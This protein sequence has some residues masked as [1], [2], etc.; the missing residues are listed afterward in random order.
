M[1]TKETLQNRR[2]LHASQIVDGLSELLCIIC[3]TNKPREEFVTPRGFRQK[4]CDCAEK[5]KI[6]YNKYKESHSEKISQKFKKIDEKRK[7]KKMETIEEHKRMVEDKCETVI[8]T[9]CKENKP[10]S[11]FQN[12]RYQITNHCYECR[13]YSQKVDKSRSSRDTRTRTK[14]TEPRN[15]TKYHLMS[16]RYCTYRIN[17]CKKG[18]CTEEE[19]NRILP[20][21]FAYTMMQ[22]ECSYCGYLPDNGINGLDR[23]DN[24]KWHSSDNVLSCCETCNI[25]KNDMTFRQFVEYTQK[26]SPVFKYIL[27]PIKRSFECPF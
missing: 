21:D 19:F 3:N 7:E 11:S 17:D 24:S 2:I 14:P 10:F 15:K 23:V 9:K 12:E 22:R 16:T 5:E 26:L 18:M 13:Q 1:P 25:S 6:A 8:C 4:C 27:T 20:K